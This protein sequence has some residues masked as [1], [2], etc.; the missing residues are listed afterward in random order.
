MGIFLNREGGI[1]LFRVGVFAAALGA[2]FV[3]GG[4]ILVQLDVARR[5]SPFFIDRPDG[6]T[7]WY[8]Q[9]M[10]DNSQ[11]VVYQI[12]NTTPEDVSA[13]YQRELDD[14]NDANPNDPRREMCVRTPARGNFDDYAEGSGNVPYF[15]RCVFNNSITGGLGTGGADQYTTVTIQPGIRDNTAEPAVD[16]TGTTIIIY[17]QIW[18]G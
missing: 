16:L 5:Q 3:I 9:Q 17:D 11:Q 10:G 6:A 7:E 13:F 1:S 18:A 15:Y 4:Y 14:H 2:I 12:Q 8:R